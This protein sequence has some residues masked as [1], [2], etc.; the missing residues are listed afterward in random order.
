MTTLQ[1]EPAM[2]DPQ[3][4]WTA[5]LSRDTRFDGRFVYAVRSTGV[6]C[7]PTCP[8]RR[9]RQSQAV[10]FTVPEEASRAGYR[11]CRRCRSTCSRWR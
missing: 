10:F 7:R 6:Y 4:L 8:S 1:K 11:P 2:L 3:Q 9:P 5:V